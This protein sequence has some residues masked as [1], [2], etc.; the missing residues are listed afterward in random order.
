M[1]AGISQGR[2]GRG[3][4][5]SRWAPGGGPR[6][7]GGTWRGLP[8]WAAGFRPPPAPRGLGLLLY[9]PRSSSPA[10]EA[11]RA[12]L[13]LRQAGPRDA[14]FLPR[15]A[16]A[17]ASRAG[18]R[19]PWLVHCRHPLYRF[20]KESGVCVWGGQGEPW[21][22]PPGTVSP[23][24][25]EPDLRTSKLPHPWGL[26]AGDC[27]ATQRGSWVSGVPFHSSLSPQLVPGEISQKAGH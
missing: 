24:G 23:L 8:A 14:P 10:S 12:Q 17:V 9:L 19:C 4:A 15:G 1:P 6:A 18:K 3:R 21:C 5:A 25:L 7:C 20:L 13:G 27:P 22:C 16:H 26:P 2:G 11:S